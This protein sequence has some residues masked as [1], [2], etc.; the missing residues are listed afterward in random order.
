MC[1]AHREKIQEL[2]DRLQ[3]P[4]EERELF[5]EHMV[6]SKKKNLDAVSEHT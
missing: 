5:S 1:E 6:V 4:Q 2:W 3:V